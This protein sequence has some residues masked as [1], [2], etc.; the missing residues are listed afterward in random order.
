[1]WYMIAAILTGYPAPGCLRD[2]PCQTQLYMERGFSTEESC[3]RRAREYKAFER[4]HTP[5]RRVQVDVACLPVDVPPAG[6][7]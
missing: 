4:F 5:G 6:G 2:H 1:M 3:N 7:R